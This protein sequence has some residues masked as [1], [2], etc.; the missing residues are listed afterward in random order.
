MFEHKPTRHLEAGKT[1]AP[2]PV[3]PVSFPTGGVERF[4]P[5]EA[6]LGP[7]PDRG[8]QRASPC[9]HPDDASWSSQ[10]GEG[11]PL[12]AGG[13]RP[14]C[15]HWLLVAAKPGKEGVSSRS[16][17]T[18][19][20][21]CLVAV[22]GQCGPGRRER[23]AGLARAE[24]PTWEGASGSL[25]TFSQGQTGLSRRM[26]VGGRAQS[27]AVPTRATPVRGFETLSSQALG[28]ALSRALRGCGFAM[29]APQGFDGGGEAVRSSLRGS[30][31]SS[32]VGV[33]VSVL[34]ERA[35]GEGKGLRLL[36]RNREGRETGW[37]SSSISA[38]SSG[39]TGMAWPL[40]SLTCSLPYIFHS[41]RFSRAPPTVR[42]A[43]FGGRL[44]GRGRTL[45]CHKVGL[46]PR[47]TPL[48]ASRALY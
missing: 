25:H 16:D 18:R 35:R 26:N 1:L 28:T 45:R 15:P 37:R 46:S 41:T 34:I 36:E 21:A 17:T 47:L 20:R 44:G 7:S 29:V 40:P 3:A 27:P 24:A 31:A 9:S 38:G 19:F 6:P 32:E 30:S 8:A 23:P 43:G 14:T 13:P 12:P 4:R 22:R 5:R 39:P 48:R 2:C 33:F 11:A 10:P 42:S